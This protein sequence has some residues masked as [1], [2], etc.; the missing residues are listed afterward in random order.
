MVKTVNE[1]DR[2][3]GRGCRTSRM[4]Q[5]E[6][7]RRLGV[8]QMTIS[9]VLNNQ[10]GV[11]E[12]LKAKICQAMNR[13]DYVLDQIATGLRSKRTNVI[14]LVI[15]DVSNTYFPEITRVIEHRAREHG[16][17]TIL[18]NTGESYE[19]EQ[20]EISLMRGFRVGGLIIAPAGG[21]ADV[22]AYRKL[23]QFE[24]PFV[25]VDRIKKGIDCS[26]VLTDEEKGTLK[27]GRYLAG[28]GY[29]RW[30]YL[31]GPAG[32][33]SS[34]A[35]LRGMRRGLAEAKGPRMSM[36]RAGFQEP[37][38]YRAIRE[39]LRKAKPDVV[40]AIND[41]V[42]VGAFRYFKEHGIRVPQDIALVGFSDLQLMDLLEVPLTTVRE[43]TAEIG[44]RAIEILLEE[45]ID[46][47]RPK[48]KIA[49]EPELILRESA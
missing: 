32:V 7:A 41:L 11:S 16:Y 13:N 43:P 44:R 14:G 39:L 46:P 29:R 15:P 17:R 40:V 45:I 38:G 8:S 34:E 49:L 28:K 48:Q 1:S 31:A 3:F 4:T 42:A 35:H 9:R 6:L 36:V 18:S 30:G 26:Y 12:K 23:Q 24:V 2:D 27:I 21:S 22:A 37:D 25:F 20:A 5:T 47:G 10:P 19:V 33:S